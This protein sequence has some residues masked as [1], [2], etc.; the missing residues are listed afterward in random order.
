MTDYTLIFDGGSRGNPGD[1]YGSYRLV[2]NADKKS[3]IRRLDFGPNV[4]NN[5][6]E[7][8]ALIAGLEDL[9]AMVQE[10]GKKPSDFSVAILGDSLL[11][12][13]QLN[14]HWKVRHENMKPL[15]AVAVDLLR[16]FGPGSSLAWH[17]RANSVRS[18]GH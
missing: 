12:T 16:A 3:K 1:G 14:G 13:E 6:A 4:T 17:R 5:V 2:R 18:L 9:T 11:V 8:R 7:Y 10:S 15:Y